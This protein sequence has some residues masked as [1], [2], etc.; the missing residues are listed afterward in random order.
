MPRVP[1][2]TTATLLISKLPKSFFL[3]GAKL[4]GFAPKAGS[5]LDGQRNAHP[6]AD[7]Q[8][9]QALLGLAARHL[10]QQRDEHARARG[11]DGVADGDR[12]AVDVD[13]VGIPAEIL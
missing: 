2:V 11:A 5:A 4:R 7:A 13:D 10:V 12:A 6:A 9:R 3:S 8:R 1:P